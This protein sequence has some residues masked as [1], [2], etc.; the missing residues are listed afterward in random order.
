[1]PFSKTWKIRNLYLKD[2]FR[3]VSPKI[4]LQ[5]AMGKLAVACLGVA[6]AIY[7]CALQEESVVLERK[8][9]ERGLECLGLPALDGLGLASSL[10]LIDVDDL[11]GR[12]EC[13]LE[14][15]IPWGRADKKWMQIVLLGTKEKKRLEL[16]GSVGFAFDFEGNLRLSS[17][18]QPFWIEFKQGSGTV[19]EGKVSIQTDEIRSETFSLPMKKMEAISFEE[20]GDDSP[21]KALSSAFWLGKDLVCEKYR[22]NRDIYDRIIIPNRDQIVDYE[23]RPSD[24]LIY[25]SG[26]W[27]KWSVEGPLQ[28][29]LPILRVEGIESNRILFEGWDEQGYHR[30][31]LPKG[32][33]PSCSLK[34]EELFH[35]IRLRSEKQISCL[36]EKQ[37]LILRCG[38]WVCKEKG[39]WR[40]LRREEDKQ[41]VY[42]GKIV[43]ELFVFE[44][45][46]MKQ[47]K[48]F[49]QG[50]FFNKEKA[51]SISVE[52]PIL[53]N[54]KKGNSG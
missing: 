13:F 25:S 48:Q 24:F 30:F 39:R 42:S 43:G 8:P 4:I 27:G 6:G 21:F 26:Q 41:K 32:A 49:L 34:P 50:T 22:T 20:A 54:G 5:V 17:Q 52:V 2:R 9:K 1:M 31:F 33:K 29:T 37:A 51:S 14:P 36:L 35:S 45:I 28:S 11:K 40:I 47:N 16:P 15:Q 10:R 3:F 19:L 53:S 12:M 18:K 23:C 7:V 44:K 38:D 46:M